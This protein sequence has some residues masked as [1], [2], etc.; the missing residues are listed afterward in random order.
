MV[1]WYNVV[2][3]KTLVI[4]ITHELGFPFLTN[5]YKGDGILGFEHFSLDYDLGSYHYY[6]VLQGLL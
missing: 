6:L 4:I 3:S 1:I 2:L 5:H